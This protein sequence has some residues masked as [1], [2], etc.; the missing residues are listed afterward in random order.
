MTDHQR[1]LELRKELNDHNYRYYVLAQPIISDFTF[2]QLL[3]ELQDLEAKHPEWDDANSPTKR[4]GGY[5]TKDFVTVKHKS[6]ML[7]L[8]N[9]YSREE[10]EDFIQRVEKQL[11]GKAE[12][13]CELKYDGVAI[14][15]HYQEGKLVQALTRGDGTQGDDVTA[16]VR[17][18]RSIPLQLQGDFPAELEIRGEIFMTLAGFKKLNEERETQGLEMFANPRNSAAGSL[19]M[20]DSAVVATRPLDSFLYYVISNPRV[21]ET[22]YASVQKAGDWGFKVPTQFPNY[23]CTAK[24]VDDILS[25]IA[26][27]DSNR[28]QLPFE[29]DGVVIKVNNYHQQEELGF[30]AKSPRWAIAYKFK[31]EA[32]ATILENITY[33]V[34]RTGAI[35]PV[36]NLKPVLLAGTTVKRASLYNADQIEKLGLRVG[37]T[38]LV[39]KGGEIIPKITGVDFSLRPEQSQPFVYA[40]HCPECNTALVRQEGEA[41]HYCPNTISCPPQA[42]GSIQ[43]FISRKAMDIEGLGEE[44][45]D[46]LYKAGLI[47]TNADLYDLTLEQ[48]LPLERMAEKSALNLL[49]GVSKSKEVPFE[50]LLFALGIRYVG[51]TVA[52]KLARH[53]GS[54]E[55]LKHANEDELLAVEEIGPRIAQSVLAFFAEEQNNLLL[56]QLVEAGLQTKVQEQEGSS[57]ALKGF[58]FVVSGVFETFSRDGIKE[59]IEKNGGK[60]ASS[61]S[62]KTNFLVAGEGMGPSKKAKAESLGVRVI[63]EVELREMLNQ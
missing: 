53:F 23:I 51:E 35:T 29:I 50:R 16:N 4:V 32:A 58:T 1:I 37:D 15:L 19:K 11:E 36:A 45:V 5:I 17:T 57:E 3:K 14:G 46:Q 7:S 9:T 6:P 33:Q 10:L 20:Q 38:V 56:Q 18:I 2:D 39:E 43:H 61:V 52:K 21:A 42:K 26:Y 60:V 8:G 12:F 41:L 22:H 27:W 55:Q 44:T 59:E 63:S 49:A 25:F 47:K 62:A 34:G 30:T 31:A 40:T 28:H 24:S 54:L 13:V 48:L